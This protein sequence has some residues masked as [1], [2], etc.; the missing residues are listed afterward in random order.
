VKAPPEKKRLIW[1][2][3]ISILMDSGL[4]LFEVPFFGA[5]PLAV[6]I[7]EILELLISTFLARDRIK[8]T[9]LDRLLGF[10]PIPGVTA[11]TVHLV[12]NRFMN[13]NSKKE[14]P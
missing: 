9:W 6:T 4:S 2:A 13:S 12:R 10:L 1:I 11:I 14:K 3:L 5:L 8:L 7:E